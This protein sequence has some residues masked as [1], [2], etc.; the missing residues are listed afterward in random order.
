MRVITQFSTFDIDGVR[1]LRLWHWRQAM[2]QRAYEQSREDP[3]VKMRAE[4]KI[5]FHL[6][7]VVLL[8]DFFPINGDT[9]EK[10]NVKLPSR[11]VG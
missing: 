5:S 11:R 6:K 10:D 7:Q 8:N 1:H 2:K 3:V 4:K 9:A